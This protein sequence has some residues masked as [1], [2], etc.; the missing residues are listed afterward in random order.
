MRLEDLDVL[1]V[2]DHEAMRTMLTRGLTAAGVACVRTAAGGGEALA[3]LHERAANVILADQ[4]MPEMDGIAFV[5]AVRA[6]PPFAA[7]RILRLSGAVG[8][9]HAEAARAAGADAVLVKPAS[10]RELLAAIAALFD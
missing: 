1:I 7:A 5:A 6:L 2:D 3:L 10:P 9:R 8:T 4:N